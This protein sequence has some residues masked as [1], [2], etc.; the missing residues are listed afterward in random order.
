MK[1]LNLFK[2]KPAPIVKRKYEA[3]VT[4]RLTSDWLSSPASADSELYRDLKTLRSRSRDLYINN[5]YTRRFLKR[6]STNV[7]GSS[8]ISL[9]VR[10]LY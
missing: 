1:F 3:A 6:T 2:P 9:Q 4:S 8:G 10:A 7:I 5:D